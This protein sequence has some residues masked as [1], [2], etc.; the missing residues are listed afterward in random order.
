MPKTKFTLAVSILI[1]ATFACNALSPLPVTEADVPRV[2]IE[3][4][5]VA[6]ESG[7]GIVLDVRSADAYALSHVPGAI[8]NPVN[9]IEN[10]PAIVDLDKDQ[11]IITYCT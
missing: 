11:W 4:A 10:N 6:L 2:S 8:N 9:E 3:E 1:L 5:R 7:A